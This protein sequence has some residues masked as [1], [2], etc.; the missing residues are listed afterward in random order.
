MAIPGVALVASGAGL[1][2]FWSAMK[3]ENVTST[4]R[5]VITGQQPSGQNMNPVNVPA[6]SPSPSVADT[7]LSG[8]QFGALAG[9]P[10]A[11]ASQILAAAASKKG[12]PY[13][14][15]TGHTGNPCAS[16]TT[17]CSSYV[18]C[19]LNMVGAMKGS[20]NTGGLSKLGSKVTYAQRLPGDII[21]W[22][23]GTGG[24][25]CGI[26]VDGSRMWNN[27]CTKCGG[28]QISKYPTVTRTAATAIV[29]RF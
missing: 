22:N 12:Q 7:G 6:P 19:V 25:H 2:F 8:S 23:G 11:R 5:E 17:D 10:G 24:G 13:S 27:P 4:L 9:V 21:V 14:Y 1:L 28:V 3:G 15:G 16:P 26:I 20:A 18:S 29:R